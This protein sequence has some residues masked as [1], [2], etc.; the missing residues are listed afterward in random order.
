MNKTVSYSNKEGMEKSVSF[1][2]RAQQYENG[3]NVTIL[4]SDKYEIRLMNVDHQPREG[5]KTRVV[6]N[7]QILT[8]SSGQI[9][10]APV[11]LITAGPSEGA[12]MIGR[13]AKFKAHRCLA[14]QRSGDTFYDVVTIPYSEYHD[15]MAMVGEAFADAASEGSQETAGVS[16]SDGFVI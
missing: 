14:S 11:S 3:V 4:E 15:I 13:T 9:I 6:Y 16:A 8:K 5:A 2:Q 7:A 1:N 10:H 12:L